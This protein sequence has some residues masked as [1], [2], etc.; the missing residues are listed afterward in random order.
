[1]K[2][3]NTVL[4]SD[5]HLGSPMS[6]AYDLLAAL[7]D[8]SF[9]KLVIVGDM[10][11]DLNFKRL[12][13][14]HWELLSHI[15]RISRRG[16]EVV[17]LQGN[18]DGLFYNF[19]SHL[20]DIPVREEYKWELG[21]KK[22]LALH[23][24]QFDSFLSADRFIGR[25]L[26]GFYTWLQRIVSSHTF[27]FVMN[28]LAD[29]W[30]RLTPQVAEQ[31]ILHAKRKHVDA[32]IC[33]HTHFVYNIKQNGIEYFNLGAWNNRPSY[34]LLVENDGSAHYKVVA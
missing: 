9:K 24:H 20:L 13:T 7:K 29:R 31:A 1:M 4:F 16:V 33:G 6:R 10:F 3:V 23:G 17:W 18:H 14:T 25:V 8:I 22:F 27:D 30:Q 15:G 28:K 19:M 21:G 26:G 2:N 5:V 11:E 32:V 12:T 34:L